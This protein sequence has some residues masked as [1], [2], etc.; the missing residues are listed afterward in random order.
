MALTYTSLKQSLQDY[1]ISDETTFV[2][3]IPNIIKLAEDRILKNVQLPD[4]KKTA[5]DATV[6]GN[7]T[8]SIPS[9]FL[10]PYYLTV[11]DSGVSPLIFK[12]AS[13]IHEAFPAS[14]TKATPKYYAIQDDT[15]FLL[16]PT[17]DS[18]YT[19]ELY[20]FYR[21]AS[22]VDGATSWLGTNAEAALFSSCL[23]EAYLFLKGD[24]DLLTAYNTRAEADI[25]DLKVLAEGRNAT[26]VNRNG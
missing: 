18:N 5:A 19:T 15:T 16:G 23:V 13:Y 17:P 7:A 2:A 25:A 10:A 8:L 6:D 1:L 11:D 3:E 12:L 14:G 22:I 9:D 21:P 20:Y 26:D 24:A 4:F